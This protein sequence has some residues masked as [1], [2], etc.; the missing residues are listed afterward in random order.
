MGDSLAELIQRQQQELHDMMNTSTISRAT[1]ENKT[2]SALKQK[3]KKQSFTLKK[4]RMWGEQVP[5]TEINFQWPTSDMIE[6]LPEDVNLKSVTFASRNVDK[7][8]LSSA[9][10]VLSNGHQSENFEYQLCDHEKYE[11]STIDARLVRK[12][13]ATIKDDHIKRIDFL[14]YDDNELGTY[15]PRKYKRF[16]DGNSNAFDGIASPTFDLADNEELIGVYGVKEKQFHFTSFGFIV[17][18][19]Q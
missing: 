19:K 6:D 18:V 8:C 11:R 16:V 14:D 15:N 9:M 5:E 7:L 10:C 13:Q 17:K 2:A 4:L 12:V 3:K 1:E